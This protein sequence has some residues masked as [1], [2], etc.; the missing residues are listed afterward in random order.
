M[1]EACMDQQLGI[2]RHVVISTWPVL[3]AAIHLVFQLFENE[4]DKTPRREAN[5]CDGIKG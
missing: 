4:N 5:R 3:V 2:Q 1:T